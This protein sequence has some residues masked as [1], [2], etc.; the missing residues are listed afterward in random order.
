MTSLGEK[1]ERDKKLLEDYDAMD[2][3]SEISLRRGFTSYE[4]D[5][6]APP[7]RLQ[8]K[9]IKMPHRVRVKRGRGQRKSRRLKNGRSETHYRWLV[10]LLERTKK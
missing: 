2:F 9:V 7:Q 1:E 8:G 4:I 10:N 5:R 3:L 6:N